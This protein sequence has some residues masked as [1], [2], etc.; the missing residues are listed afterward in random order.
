MNPRQ[1]LAGRVRSLLGFG[2]GS[3]PRPEA[4]GMSPAVFAQIAANHTGEWITPENALTIPAVYAAVNA[5]SSDLA[6][7]P[8]ELRKPTG[9]KSS[10]A[11]PDHPAA[12]L[13]NRSPDG[14]TTPQQFLRALVAHA[15]TAGNGYA[16]IDWAGGY[17]TRL[18]I[19]DPARIKPAEH[20]YS[21]D[22]KPLP[23]SQVLHL[24]ALGDDG[25]SGVSPVELCRQTLGLSRAAESFA[26]MYFG[27]GATMDGFFTVPAGNAEK[28][29]DFRK[30]V[31]EMFGGARRHTPGVFSA[32]TTFSKTGGNPAESQLLELRAFQI[33]EVAR[34]FRVPP[35]KLGDYSRA[36]YASVEQSNLSY[37]LETLRPWCESMEAVL[38][39]RLLTESEQD[40]GWHWRFD[41]DSLLRADTPSRAAWI[42]NLAASGL[43]K[44][45]EGRA[46]ADLPPLGGEAGETLLVPL[47]T[48]PLGQVL[49][50]TPKPSPTP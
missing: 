42:R 9:P 11:V 29:E 24:A 6:S 50:P 10:E 25:V 17:P 31:R 28:L 26:A 14:R 38:G 22:G 2:L 39:L 18:R 3:R 45:D 34:I 1:S 40:A 32:G 19:L 48:G 37:Y 47:N 36:S 16:R 23:G 21:V 15:L 41:F 33:L 35:H 46:L 13:F 30:N 27:N 20:D 49:D 43:L 7:L 4:F 5:I 44:V 12:R 8:L